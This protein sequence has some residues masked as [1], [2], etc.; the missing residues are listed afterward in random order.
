MYCPHC[1]TKIPAIAVVCPNCTNIVSSVGG[2]DGGVLLGAVIL[3]FIFA[4]CCGIV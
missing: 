3:V 1:S 2:L 4:R